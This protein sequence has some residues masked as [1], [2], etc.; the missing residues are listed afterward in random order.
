MKH[1]AAALALGSVFGLTSSLV[2]QTGNGFYDPAGGWTYV[3]T[4]DRADG[5]AQP[6]G[7]ALDGAWRNDNGS[8]EWDGLG[9]GVGVGALGGVSARNGVLTIED[10]SASTEVIENRKLYFVHDVSHDSV[11]NDGWVNAGVTLYFRAR[12]TPSTDPLYELAPDPNGLPNGGY[13]IFNGGKGNFSVRQA[14][15]S[16][17]DSEGIVSFSLVNATE[18][19][20]PTSRLD[21]GASGLTMNR[22][23]GDVATSAVD[24]G[25]TS[26]DMNLVP[27]DPNQFHEFWIVLQENGD[28]L[29]GTHRAVV[30][31]DG[32]A[33]SNFVFDMT[34]GTGDEGLAWPNYVGMGTPTTLA[35]GGL[36]V[37]FFAYKAGVYAPVPIPEPSTLIL[38]GLGGCAF[39]MRRRQAR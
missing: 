13:G 8:D 23:N 4:G 36:D 28:L 27:T 14:G 7:V 11:L 37:D 17:G 31:M 19:A 3:F 24:S 15:L 26:G 33:T 21:F 38:F 9:R 6:G 30:Y 20:S 39:L 34:A 18:D 2:A 1:L 12:I 10:A 5:V 25:S 16:G 35:T 32:V 29:P 22:L